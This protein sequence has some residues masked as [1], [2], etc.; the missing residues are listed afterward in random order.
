MNDDEKFLDE[1]ENIDFKSIDR[2][3]DVGIRWNSISLKYS[4]II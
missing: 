1:S 2:K 3:A 4:A